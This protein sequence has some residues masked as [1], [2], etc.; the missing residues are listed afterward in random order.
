MSKVYDPMDFLGRLTVHPHSRVACSVD[1]CSV[2]QTIVLD[3]LYHC[4]YPLGRRSYNT[5][6]IIHVRSCVALTP[7]DDCTS[8]NSVYLD[9]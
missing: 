3:W 9:C 1:P 5:T 8:F 6:T 2:K 7:A 4:L